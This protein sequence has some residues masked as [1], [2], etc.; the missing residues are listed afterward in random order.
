MRNHQKRKNTK[1]RVAQLAAI[2]A[3]EAKR[4]SEANMAIV[5]AGIDEQATPAA[6]SQSK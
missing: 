1:A 2:A 6:E 4:Q 3:A 5:A